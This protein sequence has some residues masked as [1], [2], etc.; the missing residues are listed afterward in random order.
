MFAIIAH[1]GDDSCELGGYRLQ[2]NP[3]GHGLPRRGHVFRSF[4]GLFTDWTTGIV[5]GEF[6]ETVPM[7]GMSTWHFVGG[8]SGTK[9]IFLT[10][11]TVGHVFAGLAIVIVK[12]EGIDTHSTVIAVTK[13]FSAAHST[14]AAI[15]TMVRRFVI[16]HP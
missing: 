14:K 12:E 11:G 10:D 2:G 7:N 1:D 5:G 15:A 6:F 13:V 8:I 4:G 3:H 16:G 9:Q